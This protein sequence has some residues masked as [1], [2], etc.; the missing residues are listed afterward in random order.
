VSGSLIEARG[1]EFRYGSGNPVICGASLALEAGRNGAII[2]SNGCGKSTLIRLLAGLLKP[3]AGDILFEGVPVNSLPKRQLATRIA[4]V[5]QSPALV[6]PFSALEVVLTGRSPHT[7]R[8]RFENERD[9]AKAMEALETVGAAH[10]AR[11]RITELSGGERQMVAI[12]R[13]MAQEPACLLLDEPASALDLKHRTALFR[14][15]CRL[16]RSRGLSTLMVTH[17]LQFLDAAFDVVYCM[18]CGSIVAQGAPGEVLTDRVLADLYDDPSVRA[19]RMGG[20]TVI[21]SELGAC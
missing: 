10:L 7:P 9:I 6:F 2:G 13:A 15:L 18:R 12:A 11:R 16:R 19:R 1:I 5:P 8:F 21:W 20:R 4:Y 14:T 17:D 3:A